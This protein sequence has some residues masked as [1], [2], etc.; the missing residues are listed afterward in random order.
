MPSLQAGDYLGEAPLR[1]QT[2]NQI[3]EL[4][5]RGTDRLRPAHELV[6]F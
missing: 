4:I 2:P 5:G 3:E 6:E 1:F